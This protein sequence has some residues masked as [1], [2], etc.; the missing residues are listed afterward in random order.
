MPGELDSRH[1]IAESAQELLQRAGAVGRLPTPVSDIITAAGIRVAAPSHMELGDHLADAPDEIWRAVA[2]LQ[3]KVRAIFDRGRR[4]IHLSPTV[5]NGGQRAFVL[6]HEVC[7]GWLPWHV[8]LAHAD[9]ASTLSARAAARVEREC[10][11]GASELLFQGSLLTNLACGHPVEMSTVMRLARMFG[12]ST[13][14][15]F[16]RYVETHHSP[17]AGI[18]LTVPAATG[19]GLPRHESICSPAWTARQLPTRWPPVI[20]LS[21]QPILAQALNA[22]SSNGIKRGDWFCTDDRGRRWRLSAETFHNRH[23]LFLLVAAPS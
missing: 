2:A 1:A 21:A 13:R 11:F 8:D 7:H 12:A 4:E 3:H 16:R 23:R 19:Q 10:N 9:D 6:L 17:L 18:V 14:A 15:T 22:K 5:S 20:D